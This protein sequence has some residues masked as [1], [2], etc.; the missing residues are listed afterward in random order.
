MCS[1]TD[2]KSCHGAAGTRSAQKVVQDPHL[3]HEDL[4]G[5]QDQREGRGEE[6]KGRVAALRT[7]VIP[8]EVQDVGKSRNMDNG[9]ALMVMVIKFKF[10]TYG[11]ISSENQCGYVYIIKKWV[12]N[13]QKMGSR[14][15]HFYP[16]INLTP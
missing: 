7:L 10:G 16:K 13:L 5:D 9:L 14:Y 3:Q 11:Y 15:E 8:H 4:G 2:W 12:Q 6:F 1:L